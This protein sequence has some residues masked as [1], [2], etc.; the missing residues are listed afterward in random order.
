MKGFRLFFLLLFFSAL[1]LSAQPELSLITVYPGNAIY[2][3][4]GH[5]AFRYVDEDND[6]DILYNFGT[7]DFQDPEF[8]PKFVHG[9]LDYFLGVVKFRRTF[10][11]YTLLENRSVVEQKLNLT[12]EEIARIYAFLAEN[13]MPENRYYKYDFIKDNCFNS[14]QIK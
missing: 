3:A 8:V 11:N 2:S 13:A 1:A 12:P 6:I 10:K 9:Q 5:T 14:N 7:F 4:F